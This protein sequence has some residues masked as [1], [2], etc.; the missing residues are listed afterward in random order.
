MNRTTTFPLPSLD[1][2]VHLKGYEKPVP[3][4][5]AA[6]IVELGNETT[7]SGGVAK[8]R[9]ALKSC[10]LQ[11][12]V[13]ELCKILVENNGLLQTEAQKIASYALG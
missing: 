12:S 11:L 3:P 6:A 9:S 8:L 2:M 7:R 10:G 13:D 1:G 4:Q 5:V